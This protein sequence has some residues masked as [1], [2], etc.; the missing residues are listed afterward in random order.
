M[1]LLD[2]VRKGEKPIPNSERKPELDLSM[3]DSPE[4]FDQFEKQLSADDIVLDG[5]VL[6][7]EMIEEIEQEPSNELTSIIIQ[8]LRPREMLVKMLSETKIGEQFTFTV[9]RNKGHAF[10]AAMRNIL[11]RI[12]MKNA[13]KGKKL[14]KWML[15]TIGIKLVEGKDQVTL[16]RTYTRVQVKGSV[17]DELENLLEEVDKRD[18]AE[19]ANNRS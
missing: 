19:M 9:G 3:F 13:N 8:S 6:D 17:Y 7:D 4:A 16:V 12:R 18:A 14:D 5:S 2:K 15:V 10:V 11:S 1:S